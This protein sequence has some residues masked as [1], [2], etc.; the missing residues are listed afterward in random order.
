MRIIFALIGI[1]LCVETNAVERVLDFHSTIRIGADGGLAVT[2]RISVQAEGREIQRGIL[3]DFPT[4]YRD[5]FGNRVNVPFEVWRVTR[6]GEP[7]SFN[8]ERLSNGTRIRIG[9]REVLLSPGVHTYEIQY[10][11]ARQVGFFDK[12]DELYW[13]VNGN[14]WTFAFDHITAEV[15][16]PSPVPAGDI[17]VEATTGAQD[18][19]GSDYAAQTRD[20]AAAFRSTRPFPPYSGMTIVVAFPKG[21][22]T[23]P[24]FLERVG[25][26]L[27]DNKGILAAV[28]GYAVLL[29]F[30]AWRWLLVG[31]DPRAGPKVP[32]YE[33][34]PGIGPAGVRYVDQM[35]YDHR[36]TTA[37]L[38]GLGSRGFLKIRQRGGGYEVEATGKKVDW[39][40][41]EERL[42]ALLP[43][44]GK[45][46]LIGGAYNPVV[47]DAAAHAFKALERYFAE[48]MF[49]TNYGSV[50][51]G[52]VIGLGVFLV[53]LLAGLP[54]F[55][56][57]IAVVLMVG[58]L[59]FFLKIMPAYSVEGRK[60]QDAIEGLRQYLT[61]AEADEL[62]RMKAPPQT[63][64]E[65]AKFLPYAVAL[66]VETT[67]ADRFAATLGL[68]AVSAA[69]AGYYSSDSSFSASGFSSSISGMDNTVSSASTPPGSSSGS[70]GSSGGGGRGG[71]SGGGGGGGGGSGW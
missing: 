28:L 50:G 1:F 13:N 19:Q 26:F 10:R 18:A 16:L 58:T 14:G 17:K 68:A 65:F 36:C 60:L 47:Q 24:G 7:E 44:P 67:W 40:V 53:L 62:R 34:P 51:V 39:L 4:D 12:H 29:A 71:S 48:R 57:V 20:G 54:V 27:G 21:I 63:A 41:G 6:N 32:R 61:V 42:A 5:R 66:D 31:R 45:P 15:H 33:A 70:S 11:T 2:E 38:L 9:R 8:L 56:L 22:V 25:E 30:L 55:A 23:P 52:F 43:A 35:A 59:F 37:M 64:E 69:V 49:S 3:R 46:V